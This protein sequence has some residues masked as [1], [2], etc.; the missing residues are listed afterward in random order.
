MFVF[1]FTFQW[2]TYF[3]YLLIRLQ[4]NA[5]KVLLVLAKRWLSLNSLLFS[6][7]FS[8]QKLFL[9][10]MT[11]LFWLCN[12]F[13]NLYIGVKLYSTW[14]FLC[15][16]S[17]EFRLNF[18]CTNESCKNCSSFILEKTFYISHQRRIS[19]K[20][21]IWSKDSWSSSSFSFSL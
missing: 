14:Y 18:F 15:E 1:I 7:S 4:N 16:T 19:H 12:V 9:G 20:W 3:K 13:H 21:I 5:V 2:C 8:L 17:S 6:P 10:G 11:I